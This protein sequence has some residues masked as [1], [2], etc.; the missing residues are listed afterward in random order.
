MNCLIHHSISNLLTINP[1]GNT[2]ILKKTRSQVLLKSHLTVIRKF[3]ALLFFWVLEVCTVLLFEDGWGIISSEQM[4]GFL[5]LWLRYFLGPSRS[6]LSFL[7]H[8]AHAKSGYCNC[9]DISRFW[10]RILLV[11]ALSCDR[12]R[13]C[14]ARISYRFHPPL[15]AVLFFTVAKRLQGSRYPPFVFWGIR[16]NPWI[17]SIARHNTLTHDRASEKDEGSNC[18]FAQNRIRGEWLFVKSTSG[19]IDHALS[20]LSGQHVSYNPGTCLWV[21]DV[22][23]FLLLLLR[24]DTYDSSFRY[25]LEATL[26]GDWGFYSHLVRLPFNFSLEG[27]SLFV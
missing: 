26:L 17:I 21:F 15:S 20:F 25:L 2:S 22:N 3:P 1:L 11:V 4:E 10:Q 27:C 5:G 12:T 23:N 16:I 24:G 6:V 19:F 14:F 18:C 13:P 8:L 9:W 7:L